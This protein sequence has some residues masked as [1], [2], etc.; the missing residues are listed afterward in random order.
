VL[1]ADVFHTIVENAPLFAI[2]LVVVNERNELLLG[3][4]LNAPAK[5]WWFVPGGRVFKNECLADA[6]MRI[7]G[8]ELGVKQSLDSAQLLGVYEHFYDD[9]VFGSEISTHYINASHYFRVN[10]D[11]L[12]LPMGKQ[13]DDYRWVALTDVKDDPSIHHFSKV[14]LA[15]LETIIN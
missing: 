4:R 3:K 15:R 8:S 5:G 14:F 9:S 2:D 13:H 12:V 6:F 11:E 1:P 10:T 7:A